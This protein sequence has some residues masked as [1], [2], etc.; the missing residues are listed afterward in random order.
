MTGVYILY[1]IVSSAGQ[2]ALIADLRKSFESKSW[3][4]GRWEGGRK[5]ERKKWR[6]GGREGENDNNT[7]NKGDRRNKSEKWK[8]KTDTGESKIFM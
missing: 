4:V 2:M 6:V 8:Q 1:G 7:K 3:E 5:E